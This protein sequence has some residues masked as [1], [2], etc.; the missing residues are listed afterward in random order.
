[1]MFSRLD[2]AAKVTPSLV[3]AVAADFQRSAAKP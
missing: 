3:L 1:M 2:K